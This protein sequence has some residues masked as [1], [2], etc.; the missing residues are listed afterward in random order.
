MRL[1]VEVYRLTE[2]FPAAERFGLTS[3]LRRAT[4]SVAAEHR[5]RAGAIDSTRL[6][7]LPRNGARIVG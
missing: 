6:R 7:K 4:A 2:N 3:Q 5:R 1:T